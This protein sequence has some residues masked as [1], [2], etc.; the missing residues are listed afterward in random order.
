MYA[1]ATHGNKR[2]AERWARQTEDRAELGRADAATQAASRTCVEMIDRYVA[3]YLPHK[4]SNTRL[5]QAGQLGWWRLYLDGLTLAQA[6]T[7]RLAK[8]KKDLAPRQAGTINAYLAV[9]QHAFA[10]AIKEWQWLEHNPVKNVIRLPIP[11]S[12]TRKLTSAERER[13]LFYSRLAPC[14]LME[15][16]IIVALSTGPRK[17]EIRNMAFADYDRCAGTI[18]LNETKNGDRRRVR[19]FGRAAQLM[20]DLYDRRWPGQTLFF[21]S[22]GNPGYPVDFRYSWEMALERA[23]IPD[24][25]FHDLRH[26]A[27]SYLA[28]QGATLADIKEILGHRS[29]QTTQKYTHLT[30]SHTAGVVQRMNLA[31]FRG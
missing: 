23:A 19:L 21:E 12:R 26:S 24:F 16:I 6:T 25:C 9:L 2:A 1:S 22:K 4:R 18:V 30:E 28:E 27:A 17:N 29:I 8:A 31:I 11:R 15:T 13:L 5:V 14:R 10:M 20:A 7:P 3:E